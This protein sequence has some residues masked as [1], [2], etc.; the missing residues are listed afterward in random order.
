MFEDLS[1][2]VKLD[3]EVAARIQKERDELL[4]KDAKASQRAVELL[5]ELVTEQDLRRKAEDRSTTL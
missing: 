3:E 5:D 1:A 4:Q 2:R